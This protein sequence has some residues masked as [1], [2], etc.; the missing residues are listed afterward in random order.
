[1]GL[2]LILQAIPERCRM[3]DLVSEG[4]I[5]LY[6]LGFINYHYEIEGQGKGEMVLNPQN[7]WENHEGKCFIESLYEL[8]KQSPGVLDRSLFLGR[9]YHWFYRLLELQARTEEEKE[10]AHHSIYG[11]DLLSDYLGEQEDPTLRW[12]SADYCEL[13]S[14]WLSERI[15]AEVVVHF[16]RSGIGRS[17]LIHLS[18]EE[19][20]RQNEFVSEIFQ[21]FQ[22]LY[23]DTVANQ[24]AMIVKLS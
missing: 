16:E 7:E 19:A 10:I 22:N 3:L 8:E 6:L 21:E 9:A 20:E 11:R 23:K 2:D 18:D 17:G 12:N 15:P 13:I 4:K 14:I 24:E 1:M 5:D